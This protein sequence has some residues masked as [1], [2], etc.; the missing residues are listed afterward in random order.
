MAVVVVICVG[1]LL[2]L[3]VV[4]VLKMRD[5]PG[6]RRRKNRRQVRIINIVVLIKII[7]MMVFIGTTAE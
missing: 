4:G 3:L 5:V 1:F 6:P 7:R 2:V